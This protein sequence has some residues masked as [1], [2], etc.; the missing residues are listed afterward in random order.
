MKHNTQLHD[1]DM[2]HDINYINLI[3]LTILNMKVSSAFLV[4]TRIVKKFLQKHITREINIRNTLCTTTSICSSSNIPHQLYAII[5]VFSN[6]PTSEL[7]YR[8]SLNRSRGKDSRS[9]VFHLR[10]PFDASTNHQINCQRQIT[11]IGWLNDRKKRKK[12]PDESL[13][14]EFPDDISNVIICIRTLCTQGG[15]KIFRRK[16]RRCPATDKP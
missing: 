5:I 9:A 2:N 15:N 4:I 1:Y 13:D 14:R 3:L 11:F 7:I 6:N 10:F 16:N 12:I 8:L